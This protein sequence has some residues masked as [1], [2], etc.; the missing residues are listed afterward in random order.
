MNYG[1]AWR[2][3]IHG[4]TK[5]QTRLSDWTE[6]KCLLF[7]CWKY[8]YFSSFSSAQFSHSVLSNCLQPHELQHAR[9]P[10]LPPS[11]G[12]YPN[13]SLHSTWFYSTSF[14][15]LVIS[16]IFWQSTYSCI[17]TIVYQYAESF[18]IMNIP[19]IHGHDT[20][21]SVPVTNPMVSGAVS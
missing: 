21:P 9:P 12:V 16:W 19:Y 13:S 18:F 8:F 20:L 2:A 17:I 14:I 1:E 10:C 7:Q 3:A 15:I 5:S 11:P 6:L 4:V